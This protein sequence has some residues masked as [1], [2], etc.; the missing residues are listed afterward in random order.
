MIRWYCLDP[1]ECEVSQKSEDFIQIKNCTE[2]EDTSY[3][4][5][6]YLFYD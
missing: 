1:A 4:Y 6:D 3:E 5:E 2:Q